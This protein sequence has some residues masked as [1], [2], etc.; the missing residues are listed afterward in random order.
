MF[1]GE[2]GD[3]F[4]RSWFFKQ[5]GRA[6]NET[7]FFRADHPR[8]GLLVQRWTLHLPLRVT[9]NG[10]TDLDILSPGREAREQAKQCDAE[11]VA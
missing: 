2:V 6:G 8:V 5:V 1:S 10:V 3:L 4:E 7:Q 9:E 11:C